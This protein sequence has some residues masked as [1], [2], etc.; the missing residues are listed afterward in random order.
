MI[1]IIDNILNIKCNIWY[2]LGLLL[3]IG[4]VGY[5]KFEQDWYFGMWKLKQRNLNVDI[6]IEVNLQMQMML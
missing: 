3:Y 6:L 5:I 2:I 1:L 4:I